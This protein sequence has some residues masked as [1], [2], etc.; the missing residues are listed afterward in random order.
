LHGIIDLDASAMAAVGK[1]IPQF[2]M[3]LDDLGAQTTTVSVP[4]R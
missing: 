1:H 4:A 3:M 2:Q